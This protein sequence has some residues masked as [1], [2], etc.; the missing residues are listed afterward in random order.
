MM[1]NQKQS[2]TEDSGHIRDSII[3]LQETLADLEG[4][5]AKAACLKEFDDQVF[6]Q[7]MEIAQNEI[8]FLKKILPCFTELQ[9]KINTAKKEL[10]ALIAKY[11]KIIK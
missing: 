7:K 5:L 6:N 9:N 3:N 4:Y 2:D 11:E 1:S 10:D 8:D